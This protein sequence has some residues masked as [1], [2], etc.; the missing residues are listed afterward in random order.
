MWRAPL[1]FWPGAQR[2]GA[3]QEANAGEI[4]K[5]NGVPVL[6]AIDGQEAADVREKEEEKARATPTAAIVVARAHRM[7]QPRPLDPPPAPALPQRT[8]HSDG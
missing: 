1:L 6:E 7:R 3:W 4:L 8:W 5:F 2:V